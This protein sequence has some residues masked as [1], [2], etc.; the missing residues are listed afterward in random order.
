MP[1]INLREHKEG[2]R[3]IET[4]R[5]KFPGATKQEIEKAIQYGTVKRRIGNP[6]DDRFNETVSLGENGLR[7]CPV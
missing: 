4:A 3:M 1:Y 5:N 2:I 7:N 6:P